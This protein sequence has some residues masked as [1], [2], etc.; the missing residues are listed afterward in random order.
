V[1]VV[2]GIIVV[3]TFTGIGAAKVYESITTTPTPKIIYISPVPQPTTIPTIKPKP[4]QI[5]EIDPVVNCTYKNIPPKQLRKSACS[6]SLDC[7]I[8]SQWYWSESRDKCLE[9]QRKYHNSDYTPVYITPFVAPP[10]TGNSNTT[11][12]LTQ[13][14]IN[15]IALQKQWAQDKCK[16]E[17]YSNIVYLINSGQFGDPN[18]TLSD[19]EAGQAS[20]YVNNMLSN[21]NKSCNW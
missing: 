19:F 21:C 4:K 12:G 2:I 15:E 8:G 1:A 13:D 18:K 9:A 3:S 10:I 5:V 16:K 6:I 11:V 7:Q 14:Q 20:A 17:C